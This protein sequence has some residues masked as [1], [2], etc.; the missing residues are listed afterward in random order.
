MGLLEID[1]SVG[2]LGED[3]CRPQA[4]KPGKLLVPEKRTP[5]ASNWATTR[6]GHTSLCVT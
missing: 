3:S 2:R 6:R 4:R 5:A 1:K